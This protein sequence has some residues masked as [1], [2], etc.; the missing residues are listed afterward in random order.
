[1][2]ANGPKFHQQST[3][4]ASQMIPSTGRWPIT[5]ATPG[6]TRPTMNALR[7]VVVSSLIEGIIE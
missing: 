4:A 3:H 5:C 1:M 7:V 2:I 6:R